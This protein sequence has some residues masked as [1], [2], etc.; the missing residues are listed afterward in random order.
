MSEQLISR[1]GDLRRLR[2]EGFEIEAVSGHL[3]VHHVPYVTP[4]REVT[5]GTLVSTLTLKGDVTTAPDTHVAM[6]SG[7]M[8][9]DENGAPLLAIINSSGHQQLADDVA[10]DHVFS[11]KPATGYADYYEKITAYIAMLASPAKRLDADASAMTFRVVEDCDPSS[12]FEYTET[13]SPRAGIVMATAKLAVPRLAIVGLGGTGSYILDLVAKTPVGEIHLYDGDRFLQHNAFRSPGAPSRA[14]LERAPN[15]SRY[16]ATIYQNMRRGIVAHD[17]HVT[18]AN[19]E[20]LRDMDFVFLTLDHGPSRKLIV[21]KLEEWGVGFI[22]AGMGVYEIDGA[23]GGLVRVT[24]S[25]PKQ[26]DHV[27]RRDRI[28]FGEADETTSTARTSRS[29]T[30]TP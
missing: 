20:Q 10:V 4:A 30:S 16:F 27:H 15:K 19:V 9:C 3:L 1:S 5:Y 26:R 17:E 14:V 7:E 13:A 6:F 23:L 8:P 24:A 25:T 18:A 11:S 22:D 28:S 2:E 12:V 21:S 29:P